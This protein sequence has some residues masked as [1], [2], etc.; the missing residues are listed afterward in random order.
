[1]YFRG[2]VI[3]PTRLGTNFSCSNKSGAPF[4]QII[5]Y[6][7]YLDDSK[8]VQ[9][10]RL[11]ILVVFRN[12]SQRKLK[13]VLEFHRLNM[14]PCVSL[15]MMICMTAIRL[16]GMEMS[17]GSMVSMDIYRIFSLQP[18]HS[19]PLQFGRASAEAQL[20]TK[21]AIAAINL[22]GNRFQCLYG[23]R[24]GAKSRSTACVNWFGTKR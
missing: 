1:M 21:W 11:A 14:V 13:T 15:S 3:I 4:L 9:S 8:M 2:I 17:I 19:T 18:T 10:L 7:S 5:W 24:E 23:K 22:V 20:T 16:L 12:K 6:S